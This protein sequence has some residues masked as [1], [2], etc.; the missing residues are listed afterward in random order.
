MKVLKGIAI[1]LFVLAVP[2]FLVTTNVRW[3]FNEPRLYEYSID[4]YGASARPEIARGEL[5]RA[6]RETIAYFNSPQE[7]LE[8]RVRI[9]GVERDLFNEREVAHMKDVKAMVRGVYLWQAVSLLYIVGFVFVRYLVDRRR[10]LNILARVLLWGSLFTLAL[11]FVVGV[12]F[13]VSFNSLWLLFHILSFSNTL[14]ALDPQKDYLIIM[15]PGPFWFDAVMLVAG[16]TILEAV[17]LGGIAWGYL[18]WQKRRAKGKA[19]P[20]KG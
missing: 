1:G 17:L 14:W 15:F 16:A 12:A 2:V 3:A 11:F 4:R 5:V 10:I 18:A 13:L 8:V 19:S 6:A 9:M 20:Q 7:F